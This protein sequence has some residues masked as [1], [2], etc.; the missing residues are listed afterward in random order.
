MVLLS[1][2][3]LFSFLELF[4][5]W[6][7]RTAR[8]S[9]IRISFQQKESFYCLSRGFG[10]CKFEKQIE[11]QNKQAIQFLTHRLLFW[12]T[13]ARVANFF[14]ALSLSFTPQPDHFNAC[15]VSPRLQPGMNK[16]DFWRLTRK[17]IDGLLNLCWLSLSFC[18]KLRDPFPNAIHSFIQPNFPCNVFPKRKWSSN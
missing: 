13:H 18:L 6:I 17:D 10:D 15:S 8:A 4:L 9:S 5:C 2:S 3:F 14:E 11:K 12:H 7:Q 1:F 16:L